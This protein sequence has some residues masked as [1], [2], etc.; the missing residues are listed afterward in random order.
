[1]LL[2]NFRRVTQKASMLASPIV[3]QCHSLLTLS[4]LRNVLILEDSII[5][6]T[7]SSQ[8]ALNNI[9]LIDSI[10]SK[11]SV[12]FGCRGNK[13]WSSVDSTMA[14]TQ[15]SKSIFTI[16]LHDFGL[17]ETRDFLPPPLLHDLSGLKL[18]YLVLVMPP[19]GCPAAVSNPRTKELPVSRP[20]VIDEFCQMSTEV[21]Y[22]FDCARKGHGGH[23]SVV[24]QLFVFARELASFC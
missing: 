16:H 13:L 10:K 6:A 19:Y 7:N 4:S 15:L 17:L 5:P 23:C 20:R 18:G 9:L 3:L 24:S 12:P 22:V 21:G 2:G 1:M 11:N 14:S 8:F